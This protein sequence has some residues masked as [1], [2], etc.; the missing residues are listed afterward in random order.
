[1]FILITDDCKVTPL[2]TLYIQGDY[3]EWTKELIWS[4]KKQLLL[5]IYFLFSLLG[6]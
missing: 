1:M 6:Y 4:R 2:C 5:F 3:S